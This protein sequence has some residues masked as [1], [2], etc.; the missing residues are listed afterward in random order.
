MKTLL[1][2][3]V[4]RDRAVTGCD[5]RHAHHRGDVHARCGSVLELVIGKFAEHVLFSQWSSYN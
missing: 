5:G 1:T 2:L 4:E 3:R